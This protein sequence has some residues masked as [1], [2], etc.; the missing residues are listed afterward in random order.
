MRVSFVSKPLK[1]KLEVT[2]AARIVIGDQ[3]SNAFVT[4]VRCEKKNW[5]GKH[6]FIKGRHHFEDNQTLR[7]IENDV[8]SLINQYRI[9]HGE[10]PHPNTIKDIYVHDLMGKE[11]PQVKLSSAMSKT[12]Q[13]KELK[14]SAGTARNYHVRLARVNEYMQET[15]QEEVKLNEL[16]PQWGRKFINWLEH[17]KNKNQLDEFLNKNTVARIVGTLKTVTKE[18]A[19]RGEIDY[20]PL[21]ALVKPEGEPVDFVVLTE[22]EYSKLKVYQFGSS[23]IQKI[24][25]MLIFM[26]ETGFHYRE[27]QNFKASENTYISSSGVRMISILRQKTKKSSAIPCILPFS[28]L[29]QKLLEKYGG[30]EMPRI[31]VEK[32]NSYLKEI[33]AILDINKNLTSKVGRKTFATRWLNLGMSKES[34]ATMCGH[35][36][37]RITEEVYMRVQDYKVIREMEEAKKNI[38]DLPT[39]ELIQG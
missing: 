33:D 25:D 39:S 26:C 30:E 13:Q 1:N 2:I 5:D 11:A 8:K 28:D 18:A 19:Q 16:N 3:R 4:G 14:L 9:E 31:S 36:S 10:L 20:D 37:S 32:L 6:Q 29:G 27:M 12:I 24:A 17:Q 22:G 15:Q 7:I 35:S 34:I 38:F 23:K 21:G